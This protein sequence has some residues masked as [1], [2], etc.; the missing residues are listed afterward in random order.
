MASFLEPAQVPGLTH[1]LLGGE[2]PNAQVI[3][4]WADSVCLSLAYGPAETAIW[5]NCR[6]GISSDHR[7][8]DTGP[9]MQ[10]GFWIVNPQDHN[11]LYPIGAPGELVIEGP[12]VGSGYLNDKPRTEAAFI[13]PPAWAS[14]YDKR[15]N[16][17]RF[18]KTGDLTKFNTDGSLDIVGRKDSQI[19]LRGKSRRAICKRV[20]SR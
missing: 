16:R 19:K 10:C 4:R 17:R 9:P 6:T 1:L 7:L 15:G 3:S 14:R 5:T 2:F 11:E 20:R 12:I 13:A 18:Y 8:T